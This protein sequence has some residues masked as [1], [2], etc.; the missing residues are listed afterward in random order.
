MARDTA[1]AIEAAKQ[2]HVDMIGT[3]TNS[4]YLTDPAGH[5]I[6]SLV[7]GEVWLDRDC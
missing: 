1:E 2:I 6:W 7:L 5:V 4:I 3:R